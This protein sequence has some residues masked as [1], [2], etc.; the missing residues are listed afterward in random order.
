MLKPWVA[1]GKILTDEVL[2]VRLLF[3]LAVSILGKALQSRHIA[4]G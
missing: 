4:K 3:V 1:N 2:I